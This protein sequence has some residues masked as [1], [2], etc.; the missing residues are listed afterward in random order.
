MDYS[1]TPLYR[2]ITPLAAE[3][4]ETMRKDDLQAEMDEVNEQ[5]VCIKTR[6]NHIISQMQ[7]TSS[8]TDAAY[9]RVNNHEDKLMQALE[10]GRQFAVTNQQNFEHVDSRLK[11]LESQMNSCLQIAA[12][13]NASVLVVTKENKQLKERLDAI[14]ATVSRVRQWAIDRLRLPERDRTTCPALG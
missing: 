5:I 2:S 7:A 14:D 6:M 10:I 8:A 1:P 11:K 4:C 13:A 3:L 9:V 12:N